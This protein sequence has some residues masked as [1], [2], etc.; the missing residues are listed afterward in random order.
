MKKKLIIIIVILVL[1]I[2][3]LVVV[4]HKRA[5]IAKLPKSA[6]QPMAVD[7]AVARKG[8]LE[9][10]SH[11]IGEIQSY[12]SAELS[13][14]IT[15]HILSIN[16]REGDLVKKGEVVCEIDNREFID[17]TAAIQAETSAT[18][19]R[20]TGAKS[21]YETQRS[22]TDRDEKL[23]IAGA[24]S[25]EALERSHAAMDSAKAAVDAYEENIKG[26][27]KNTDAAML[28]SDYARLKA[29]FSG[30][31]TKRLAEPGDLAM[32]GKPVL[33][34]DQQMPLKVTAQVPQEL[35]KILRSGAKVYLTNG[36]ERLDAKIAKV[37]PAL[38]KNF[39]G[40]VEMIFDQSPFGLPAGA[41]VGIDIVTA[42]VNGIIVPEN[43]IVH[44][45]KGYFIYVVEPGNTIKIKQVEF[46]GSESGMTAIKGDLAEGLVVAVAQE[47]KLLSLTDGLKVGTGG[48]I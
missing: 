19:E 4:K 41:T 21:L 26:L 32:P 22:I 40:S 3:G 9:I 47:N 8:N 35:V 29:P 11:Q 38:G 13:P 30:I 5:E 1:T 33:V 18:R 31:I 2:A 24:I 39:M 16:K 10:L 42:E 15:G 43:A 14:R 46:L 45:S 36:T 34:I 23:F 44:T 37:Y 28:Q 27:E 48:K 17:R 7:T 6:S 20:F 12:T 25:K